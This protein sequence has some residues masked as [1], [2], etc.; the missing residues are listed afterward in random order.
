MVKTLVLASA[1]VGASLFGVVT[2]NAQQPGT[3]GCGPEVYNTA[4][5]TYSAAPCNTGEEHTAVSGASGNTAAPC[6]PET[7]D[8]A[9][10]TYVGVPCVAGTTYENPGWK[11]TKVPQ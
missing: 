1:L 5:Q 9:S 2:V 10:Q 3:G 7:Y 11:G 8:T 4:T 6:K